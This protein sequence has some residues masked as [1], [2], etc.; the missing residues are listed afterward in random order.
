M[1]TISQVD[2]KA[3]TGRCK[4]LL[5]GINTKMG[6][7]P[8]V[9]LHMANSPAALEAYLNFSGALAGGVLDAQFRERIAIAV[10]QINDCE[11]C[12]SAHVAL[13][14]MAG[15]SESEL[16]EAQLGRS[17][18]AKINAGLNFARSL[19]LRRMDLPTGDVQVLKDAGFTDAEV[20]ELVANVALNVYTNWFNHVVQP[21]VDFPK[22][23]LSFPV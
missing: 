8:N 18:D 3:S 10:A 14:K 12:L 5:D 23:K 1:A 13:G 4:E 22:V 15:L 20:V 11:Y 19:V 16:A 2:P 17:A 9:F 6:R 21:E 7:V